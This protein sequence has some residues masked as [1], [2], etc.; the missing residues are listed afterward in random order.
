MPDQRAF[1]FTQLALGTLVG[2][3]FIA[4]AYI[5]PYYLHENK[6]T[7]QRIYDFFMWPAHQ[8]G[9]TLGEGPQNQLEFTGGDSQVSKRIPAGEYLILYSGSSTSPTIN[10]HDIK[11]DTPL[12]I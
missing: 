5:A 10:I 9:L 7:S 4:M 3:F 1:S 11:N 12:P 2:I 8:L 6:V